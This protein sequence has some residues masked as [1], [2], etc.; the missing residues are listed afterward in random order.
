MASEDLFPSN[1]DDSDAS[2][3]D[4]IE[5][6]GWEYTP[7]TIASV[8]EEKEKFDSLTRLVVEKFGGLIGIINDMDEAEYYFG[9]YCRYYVRTSEKRMHEL[10]QY[11]RLK[12]SNAQLP[13]NSLS[14]IP[15]PASSPP[16]EPVASTSATSPTRA[17]ASAPPDEPVASTSATTRAPASEAMLLLLSTIFSEERKSCP[18][19]HTV[20]YGTAAGIQD[21]LNEHMR[22]HFESPPPSTSANDTLDDVEHLPYQDCY[23]NQDFF[24]SSDEWE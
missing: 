10:S 17:P 8:T 22:S 4:I 9:K 15:Q 3:A 7:S 18:V 6:D 20:V 11:V 12:S 23:S 19:C 21:T 2:T 16:D 14:S 13:P 1:S 5:V 24:S